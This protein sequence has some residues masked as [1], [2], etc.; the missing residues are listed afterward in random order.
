[1]LNYSIIHLRQVLCHAKRAVNC[2][3]FVQ[4]MSNDS[5]NLTIAVC[6]SIVVKHYN[7]GPDQDRNQL[8]KIGELQ[9]WSLSL[10]MLFGA[11]R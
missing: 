11:L 6:I 4:G 2:R 1:M 10:R 3:T 7:T 9:K 8:E 5:N